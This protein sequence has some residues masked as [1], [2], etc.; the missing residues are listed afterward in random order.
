[1]SAID[2][3]SNLAGHLTLLK[4]KGVTHVGRYYASTQWKRLTPQEALAVSIAGLKIFV[5]FENGGSPNLTFEQGVHDAQIAVLQ[6][7]AAKQPQQS[8]IYFALEGLPHGYGAD[9][10]DGAKAYMA[11]VNS[12]LGNAYK[13]GVYA[14]GLICKGLLDS[15]LVAYTWLSASSSFPGTKDFA[16]SNL[17]SIKQDPHVDQNWDGLSIDTNLIKPEI[18][19]FGVALAVADNSVPADN[20]ASAVGGLAASLQA[21]AFLSAPVAANTY[22]VKTNHRYQA[23]VTLGLLEVLAS[24]DQVAQFFVGLGFSHVVAT[25]LGTKRTVQGTWP[26]P[27]TTVDD[28]PRLSDIVDL[29]LIAPGS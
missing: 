11:G 18:G 4:S 9:D 1:M 24:N 5:V 21:A 6:A 27:D 22:T 7:K 23:T 20:V 25:G 2:T 10:L 29:G 26:A 19:A 17:W 16:A 14:D 8:A 3:N 15:G 13:A 28:D 12:V